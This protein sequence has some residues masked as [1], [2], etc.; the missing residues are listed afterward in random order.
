MKHNK[1][2]KPAAMLKV[3]SIVTYSPFPRPICLE[4]CTMNIPNG[5]ENDILK[6]LKAFSNQNLYHRKNPHKLSGK[7]ALYSIDVKSRDDKYRMFF[8]IDDNNICKITNLCSTD[9]H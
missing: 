8:Y 5:Y 2:V 4:K 9:T 1:K 7:D 6:T 3:P